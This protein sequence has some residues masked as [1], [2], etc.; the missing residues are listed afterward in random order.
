M[1][2]AHT[3]ELL[4]RESAKNGQEGLQDRLV[5]LKNLK[6]LNELMKLASSK[7]KKNGRKLSRK[8]KRKLKNPQF[9]FEMM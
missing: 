5:P 9:N 8:K 1:E 6:C 2:I 3:Q 7:K 4:E